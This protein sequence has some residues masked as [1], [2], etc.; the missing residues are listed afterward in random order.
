MSR[1]WLLLLGGCAYVTD[2]DFEAVVDADGDG[3]RDLR[4]EGTD[5]DDADPDIHPTA[6]E[7][8]YD[9]V[10]QDCAGDNDYDADGDGQLAE[11]HGGAD[12]DDTDPLVNPVIGE[13][14]EDGRDNDCD[15]EVDEVLSAVDG[16]GDGISEAEGDCDDTDPDVNP[17]RD[18][19]YYNAKD[20][21]CDPS[22]V[23]TDQ[24]ADGWHVPQDCN[25]TDPNINPGQPDNPLTPLIQEDCSGGIL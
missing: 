5:C 17:Q 24:D 12:C 22:T 7:V 13:I 1:L 4:W 2:S 21:D 10:D 14:P 19:V 18:E 8:W 11:D 15:G 25:D 20:D 16:D 23:D 6:E 9:G 3:F